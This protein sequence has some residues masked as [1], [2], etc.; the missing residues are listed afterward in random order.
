MKSHLVLGYLIFATL[1]T[2][3]AFA[4]P[5]L[6]VTPELD[7]T[8][9]STVPTS[10]Y[11]KQTIN[12]Y[13]KAIKHHHFNIK[14]RISNENFANFLRVKK[15]DKQLTDRE[16]AFENVMGMRQLTFHKS[17]S[18]LALEEEERNKRLLELLYNEKSGDHIRKFKSI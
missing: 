16:Q 2:S 14:N 12:E 6:P 1:F 15:G 10:Y 8:E 9:G 18:G 3:I 11:E 17:D 7:D 5:V 13:N 4:I